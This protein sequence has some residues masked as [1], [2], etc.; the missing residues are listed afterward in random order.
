MLKI[1]WDYRTISSFINPRK[2][3]IQ[4]FQNALP[5]NDRR[6]RPIE[7]LSLSSPTEWR[8]PRWWIARTAAAAAARR[9]CRWI[10]TT[11]RW[12]CGRRRMSSA[13]SRRDHS[14]GIQGGWCVPCSSQR[15]R[16][17]FFLQRSGDVRVVGHINVPP[18][19]FFFFFFDNHFPTDQFKSFLF[20]A[21]LL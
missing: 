3:L 7:A 18:G 15:S 9:T 5:F 2:S 1:F 14:G 4:T 17:R 20:I 6:W 11:R 8:R 13:A 10:R 12:R 16:C 19:N 21:L